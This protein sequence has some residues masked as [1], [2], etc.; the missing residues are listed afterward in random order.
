V[1]WSKARVGTRRH[2]SHGGPDPPFEGAILVVRGDIVN[3]RHYLPWAV[4]KRLNRS[5]YHLR[6]GFQWAEGCNY[7]IGLKPTNCMDEAPLVH[8]NI[9]DFVPFSLQFTSCLHSSSPFLH[10]HAIFPFLPF[11]YFVAPF[12]KIQQVRCSDLPNR[13]G[14]IL[15]KILKI[16]KRGKR[17]IWAPSRISI[18]LQEATRLSIANSISMG[19]AAFTGRK[20]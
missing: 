9:F 16:H 18:C 12:V 3:Y 15:T 20:R 2:V 10:R 17:L 4:Q 1:P 7:R 8:T 19:S 6:C 14:P 11:R 13:I 5:I